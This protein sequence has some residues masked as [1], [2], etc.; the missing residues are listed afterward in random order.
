MITKDVIQ[1]MIG[2]DILSSITDSINHNFG[3]I[4]IDSYSCLPK[5]Y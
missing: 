3:R 1:F 4:R 2:L 5:K